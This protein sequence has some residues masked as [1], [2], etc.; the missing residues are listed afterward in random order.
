LQAAEAERQAVNFDD[1]LHTLN[2][3]GECGGIV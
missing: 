1:T 2:A 3:S